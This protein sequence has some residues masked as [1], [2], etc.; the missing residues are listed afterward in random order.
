MGNI[1]G[2][3]L[4]EAEDDEEKDGEEEDMEEV[5]QSLHSPLLPLHRQAP[6]GSM[7]QRL[8]EM[9]MGSTSS[10]DSNKEKG[11]AG[12]YGGIPTMITWSH[13]HAHQVAIQG[14]W[15]DWNTREY[16]QRI[17]DEKEGLFTIMK[18][19][20]AG[21]YHFRFIV[22][23]QWRCASHFPWEFDSLGN[24]FNVLEGMIGFG[25]VPNTKISWPE[26]PP[27]PLSTY[28]SA[29]LSAE[30][31]TAKVPELPSLLQHSLLDQ[32]YSSSSSSRRG[33]GGHDDDDDLHRD[34]NNLHLLEKPS[35]AVL[36]HLYVQRGPHL[37]SPTVALNSTHRFRNKYVSMVLYKSLHNYKK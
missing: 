4:Q 31:L 20:P 3:L 27:S 30:D 2:K 15:D 23:G 11:T 14:S 8:E 33:G 13:G 36:N 37:Q 6:V 16:L 22:D 7:P 29:P 28:D 19:L 18:V 21:V 12:E 34:H 25:G 32:P 1:S 9:M 24:I 5:S 10:D 35:P 17:D 26:S